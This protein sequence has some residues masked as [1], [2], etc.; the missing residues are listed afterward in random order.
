MANSRSKSSTGPGSGKYTACI[1]SAHM[2]ELKFDWRLHEPSSN[3]PLEWWTSLCE[4][5]DLSD[6][7]HAPTEAVGMSSCIHHTVNSSLHLVSRD[8]DKSVISNGVLPSH[9]SDPDG[10]GTYRSVQRQS[11]PRDEG[12]ITSKHKTKTWAGTVPA[13]NL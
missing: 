9:V 12:A 4:K 5:V 11:H 2:T 13:D 8:V 6:T 3:I 1:N 7:A 10:H